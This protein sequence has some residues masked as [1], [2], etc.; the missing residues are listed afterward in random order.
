VAFPFN[1]LSMRFLVLYLENF[2]PVFT[3]KNFFFIILFFGWT[4][5]GVAQ[6]KKPA[7]KSTAAKPAAV[8][9]N[10]SSF[11]IG[12]VYED[13]ILE[14]Y[15][16]L[17]KLEAQIEEKQK[18]LQ[19]DYNKIAIEYQTAFIDY[20]NS[21]KNLDSVTTEML[22]AKLKNVQDLKAKGEDF[23]RE[24]E[25]TLQS[26][27]GDGINQ[28][29]ADLQKAISE[30]AKEKKYPYVLR[31]NKTESLLRGDKMVLYYNDKNA[32]DLSDAVIVK[33]GSK[34][35]VKK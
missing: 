10:T 12:Y 16:E 11:K 15:K 8:S 9:Q 6:N 25:K 17:E 21:M 7:S 3:M 2:Y 29:K 1:F 33:L 26:L 13:Y 14:N 27:T 35:P 5:N 22:T 18:A 19:E 28:V 20:Q 4:L 34:P 31:R 32:H 30:V 23:Q 24:S